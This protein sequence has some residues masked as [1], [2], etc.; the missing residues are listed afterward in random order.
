VRISR[1]K[2]PIPLLIRVML[3]FITLIWF[4]ER[5]RGFV[6]AQATVAN[7]SFFRAL[8]PRRLPLLAFQHVSNFSQRYELLHERSAE[9]P[10]AASPGRR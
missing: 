3:V 2:W 6:P 5:F 7:V 1:C 9:G 10:P 4:H 8:L